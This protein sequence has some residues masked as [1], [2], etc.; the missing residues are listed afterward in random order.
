MGWVDFMG[1][2]RGW[3]DFMWLLR[4]YVDVCGYLGFRFMLVVTYGVG[5]CLWL[6]RV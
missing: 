5:R 6:L 1:L 2:L 4:V 3:V